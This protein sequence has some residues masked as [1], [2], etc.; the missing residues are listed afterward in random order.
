M[1]TRDTTGKMNEKANVSSYR[2]TPVRYSTVQL[3]TAEVLICCHQSRD[4]PT[5]G[6]P[7][8]PRDG[9]KHNPGLFLEVAF[10]GLK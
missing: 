1:E 4:I 7:K 3:R 5:P 2:T 9:E 8:L 6:F 10:V